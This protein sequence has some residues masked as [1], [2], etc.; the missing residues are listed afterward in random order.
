MNQL[1]IKIEAA[2]EGGFFYD[3]YDRDPAGDDIDCLD[4]GQCT[5]ALAD[6]LEMAFETAKALIR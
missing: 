2:S 4:G 3:V 1:F 6:A 5:G